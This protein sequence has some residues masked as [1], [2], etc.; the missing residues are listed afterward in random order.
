MSWKKSIL[1]TLY[2]GAVWCSGYLCGKEV[3]WHSIIT[4]LACCLG[5]IYVSEVDK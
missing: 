5:A 2:V 4:L 3:K 1:L